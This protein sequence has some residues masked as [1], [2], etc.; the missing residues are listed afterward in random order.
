MLIKNVSRVSPQTLQT[1]VIKSQLYMSR[2][3]LIWT[4]GAVAS[5]SY[6]QKPTGNCLHTLR[7]CNVK[8]REE[9]QPLPGRRPLRRGIHEEDGSLRDE[10]VVQVHLLQGVG[11]DDARRGVLDCA[12]FVIAHD[13][14]AQ[15]VVFPHVVHDLLHHHPVRRQDH[16]VLIHAGS[17]AIRP[18]LP[19]RTLPT[20]GEDQS[21]RSGALHAAVT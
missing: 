2:S 16:S 1:C 20:K 21:P 4:M 15:E 8:S 12:G 5:E 10:Q 13:A 18:S 14:L 17:Q 3:M 7:T 9:H 19:P 6:T 11:I